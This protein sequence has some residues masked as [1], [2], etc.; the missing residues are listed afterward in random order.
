MPI[1]GDYGKERNC[2]NCSTS[3]RKNLKVAAALSLMSETVD[4][5]DTY[6]DFLLFYSK[7]MPND[8]LLFYSKKKPNGST[9]IRTH[10]PW[11]RFQH[12]NILRPSGQGHLCSS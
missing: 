6:V 2:F 10:Y 11:I 3:H 1:M 7:K 4:F 12:N 9:E 5:A 8:F